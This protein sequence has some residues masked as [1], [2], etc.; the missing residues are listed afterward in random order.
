M[1]RQRRFVNAL[2][3]GAAVDGQMPSPPFP[4]RLSPVLQQ[5]V[6]TAMEAYRSGEANVE[7]AIRFAAVHGWYEGHIEGEDVCGGCDFRGQDPDHARWLRSY[8]G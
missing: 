6:A 2:S 4:D 8:P 5:I 1:R 7:S 3:T